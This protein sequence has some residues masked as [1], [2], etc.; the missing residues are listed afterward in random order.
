MKRSCYRAFV[1]LSRMVE[2]PRLFDRAQDMFQAKRR[3]VMPAQ[4]GIQC[5]GGEWQNEKPGF[6]PFGF[7]QDMLSRERRK[8]ASRLR[9]DVNRNPQP[10]AEDRLIGSFVV[11]LIG[12][13]ALAAVSVETHAQDLE[14]RA[15]ANTPVG[16]NFLIGGYA[17]SKGTVGSN[18]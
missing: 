6:P 18:Q 3:S 15:Y 2:I 16:L 13:L 5:G 11:G 4:A 17:Y 7:A 14:P 1:S 8:R 12:V 10:R 9:A